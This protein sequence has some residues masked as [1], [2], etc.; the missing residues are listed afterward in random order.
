MSKVEFVEVKLEKYGFSFYVMELPKGDVEDKLALASSDTGLVCRIDYQNFLFGEFI[1]NLERL[2]GFIAGQTGGEPEE[3]LSLRN[4]VAAKIYKVNP[5]LDPANVVLTKSGILKPKGDWEGTPLSDNPDWHRPT[6]EINPYVIIDEIEI[7]DNPGSLIPTDNDEPFFSEGFDSI[8]VKWARLNID[9]E[10]RKFSRDDLSFIFGSE[11]SFEKELHYKVHIIQQCIPKAN[12]VFA[13][14][15][16]TGLTNDITV[17]QLADELYHLCIEV[18]PFLKAEEID[19]S[20]FRLPTRKPNKSRRTGRRN[21]P[22]KKKQGSEKCFSDVTKEEILTLADRMKVKVV[23]QAGAIDKL[24]DT[25]QIASC[26]L[27]DP[28]LPIAVYLLCGTTGIGKT[29]TAKVLA[30]ELCGSRDNIVRIDCSEYT[31]QHDVQKLLGSPPSYVGYEDG[32]FL[33]NAVQ[34]NPFSIVLF[35]EIEKA[36]NKLFDLLL[37]IMDDARLTDGK[38]TVT[39]FKDCIILM[40]SNIGVAETNAVSRTM[41]FG[42]AGLLTDDKRAGA[43]KEALKNRFRPEFLNRIDDT[44][45]F[46]P[47]GKEDA[48]KVVALLLDKVKGHLKSQDITAEFTSSVLNMVFDKGFSKKFGAR[49]LQRTIDKEVIKPLAK[50]ILHSD[51]SSGMKIRV[52]YSKD[53]LRVRE[54]KTRVSRKKKTTA[55]TKA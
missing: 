38:G 40:T 31:Q 33:T 47:L 29:L 41:G 6:E 43:L 35:D 17:P 39:D 23:G 26:G 50:L 5:A 37:Q 25:I 9:L 55:I 13:L 4:K 42:D 54:I 18:N 19:L 8:Q 52:D 44:L 30:E 48:L 20:Q 15:D 10:I 46:T 11:V 21:S 1:V 36:H 2:F 16:A 27:R 28:D 45:R 34:D 51:I 53:K 3:Q 32:G 49:P 24:V 22:R 14:C 7:L 12:A